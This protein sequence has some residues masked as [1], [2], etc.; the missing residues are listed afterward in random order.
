MRLARAL[1]VLSAAAWPAAAQTT[2]LWDSSGDGLLNGTYYFRH[3]VWDVGNTQLNPL[4][5]LN[6]AVALYGTVVF[7]G[8]GNYSMTATEYGLGSKQPTA[9]TP[10]PSGTYT[11][12]ASGHGMMDNPIVSGDAVHGVV[13]AQGIFLGSSTEGSYN[14]LF[15]AVP[16][17]SPAATNA[18]FS[19][20]YWLSEMD[21]SNTGSNLWSSSLFS[22]RPNGAGKVDI[23]GTGYVAGGSA[24]GVQWERNVQ[25]D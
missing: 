2:P 5:N 24:C 12:A 10:A 21:M 14:D 20:S 18:S 4:S 23:T 22:V 25:R 19:G 7:D 1:L 11:I 8:K 17:S 13:S 3:V 16:A 6:Y 9:V 15:I